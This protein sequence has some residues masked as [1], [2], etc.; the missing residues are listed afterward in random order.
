MSSNARIEGSK[1]DLSIF[2][3]NLYCC[4]WRDKEMGNRKERSNIGR[5]ERNRQSV[6][7]VVVV[8]VSVCTCIRVW[9]NALWRHQIRWNEKRE[10]GIYEDHRCGYRET[11]SRTADDK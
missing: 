9:I 10:D 11:C 4:G 2:K 7:V 6:R 5:R 1:G 3:A 8:C